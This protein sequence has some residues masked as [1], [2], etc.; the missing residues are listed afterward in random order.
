MNKKGRHKTLESSLNRRLETLASDDRVLKTILGTSFN[1]RHTYSPGHL[2]VQR[3]INAGF[4]VNGYSGNGVTEIFVYC[5][6]E[7]KSD[8][9]K[10]MDS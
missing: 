6:E 4:K 3:E 8:V 10:L 9:K 5:A 2:K 1:C 7:D